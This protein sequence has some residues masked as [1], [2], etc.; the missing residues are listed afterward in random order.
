MGSERHGELLAPRRGV[1]ERVPEIVVVPS[2]IAS[3]VQQRQG[4]CAGDF[5]QHVV[6]PFELG[7]NNPR[8]QVGDPPGEDRAVGV[9][10]RC[11]NA[12]RLGD[13]DDLRPVGVGN[14][15]E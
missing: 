11:T 5:S 4:A 9:R 2:S 3:D 6:E 7:G 8:R 12:D 1:V 14:G 10:M 13:E 15:D